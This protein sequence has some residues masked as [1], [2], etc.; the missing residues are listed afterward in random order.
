MSRVLVTGAGGYIGAQAVDCLAR[1]GHEVTGTWRHDRSRLS[2]KPHDNVRLVQIDLANAEDVDKLVVPDAFD[3]IVHAAAFVGAADTADT[4]R[5]A[6][7]SNVQAQSNLVA[8]ALKVGC[9]RFLFCSTIS[10]YGGVGA[11][12]G[13]YREKDAR[14]SSIYAWSKLAGEQVLD[15]AASL[16]PGFTALSLRLA[17]VHGRGRQDG[18]LRAIST[19]ARAGRAITLKDPDSRFR[20]LFI[21]DFMTALQVLVHAPLPPG[22]Q[23]CNLASADSFTL[24]ELAVLINRACNSSSVVETSGAAGRNEVMNIDRAVA[25]WGYAP[26]RLTDFLP[27]YLRDFA[28]A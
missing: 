16:G 7:A 4:L 11:G 19:A 8:A 13:G 27:S 14:P 22:H 24:R 1:A 21:D 2:A 18:A 5:S 6:T 26:T 20:W 12:P 9:R 15:F 10:V 23:V 3:V 28:A 17:G 25:L